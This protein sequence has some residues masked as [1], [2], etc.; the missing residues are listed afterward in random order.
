MT[1]GNA[2]LP[3]TRRSF[4]E[5]FGLVGGSTLVMSA[6]RSWDLL[7]AQAGPRPSLSGRANGTR[8]LV[9]GAGLSGLVTAYE[10]GKLG[11]NVRVLEARDR[12]GGVTVTVRRGD[13]HT[14][15]GPGGETQ[16]C[17]FAEGLYFNGGPWRLPNW[18]TG[19]LGYCKEL[20]VPLEIFVNEDESSYFYYEGQNLG[21]LGG[22]RV[23]L[24]E[25]KADM[26]GYTCELMAKAVNQNALDVPL[27][28][29]DKERFVSF[30]VNEGY[31]D[32]ADRV[33][34]KNTARGGGDPH[35]LSA[36]LQSG[37]AGR[38]RSVVEGVGVSPMFQPSGGMDQITKAFQRTL[39][40]RIVLGAEI[41]SWRQTDT[42][43]RV[44]YRNVKTG[45]RAE[46]TADYCVCCLPLTVVR[47]LDLALSPET[48][49]AVKA[50]PYSAWAKMGLQ[51]K[52]RFWEEDDHIF[53]G[54]LYTN[55]PLGDFAYPSTGYFGAKGVLLGFNG[56]GQIDG[57]VKR[58][59]KERVEHVLMHASKVHPQ[60]RAEYE[61]AYSMFWERIPYTLGGFAASAGGPDRQAVLTRPDHRVYLGC[62]AVGGNGGW[63]EGAVAIAWRQVRQLHERVMSSDS[64]PTRPAGTV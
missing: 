53:G 10:L 4:L 23:R 20:G 28:A 5:Q 29:E 61:G 43:V 32:S 46:A 42:D 22:R 64:R 45:A 40:D 9:L 48:M 51:M 14:E 52:R 62:A 55:L 44:A 31:L 35:S 6:M 36:L 8:V 47:T 2:K 24:R 27:S 1:S 38:I 63:Q 7:A 12:V 59:V 13:R 25:V 17:S 58:P 30:L 50:V 56:N 33:Y 11:Y 39:A 57:L 21:P 18:H 49:A 16:V 19:V 41:Q 15:L 60:M 34:K 26:I 3:M 54:H 37:L